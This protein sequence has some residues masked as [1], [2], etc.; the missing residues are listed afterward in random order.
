MFDKSNFIF[1]VGV[2]VLME[3][4]TYFKNSDKIKQATFWELINCPNLV[5]AK[6]MLENNFAK[7][8]LKSHLSNR[9]GPIDQYIGH[10]E[11]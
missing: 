5:D 1:A 11:S 3:V 6:K 7:Q 9:Y 2:P 10:Y 4:D 8:E